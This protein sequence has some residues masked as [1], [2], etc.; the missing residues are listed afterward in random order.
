MAIISSGITITGG[1]SITGS[2]GPAVT[3]TVE[4]LV[5]A[6]GG[7]GGFFISGGGGAGGLSYQATRSVTAS[8]PY[9]MVVAVALVLQ[10]L[11]LAVL[12]VAAYILLIKLVP[13]P[14]RETRAV[15]LVMD[16]AGVTVL[17][18]LECMLLRAVVVP[19]L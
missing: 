19:A 11:A 18:K 3:P 17:T 16:L 1:W 4:C 8:T 10:R 12:A 9:T 14:H 15:R 2:D 5:V 13:R 7:G 6:G